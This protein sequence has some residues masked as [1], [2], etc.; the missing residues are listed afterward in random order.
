MGPGATERSADER[1]TTGFG[2]FS[3]LRYPVKVTILKDLP[4]PM[5]RLGLRDRGGAMRRSYCVKKVV[6]CALIR[7]RWTVWI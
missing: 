4:N 1:G 7:Y 3:H 5:S 2:C 6:L